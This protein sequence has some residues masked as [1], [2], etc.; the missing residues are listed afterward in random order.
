MTSGRNMR[1]QARI[2]S[3]KKVDDLTVEIKTSQCRTRSCPRRLLEISSGAA[4]IRRPGE[5]RLRQPSDRHRFV[6]A[7]RVERTGIAARGICRI[8][9]PGK[10]ETAD[11]YVAA[12]PELPGSRQLFRNRPILP[13]GCRSTTSLLSRG[14]VI[15][16]W[17]PLVPPSWRGSSWRPF[18]DSPFHDKRGPARRQPCYR[19][20][21]LERRVAART[22]PARDTSAPLT[23]H[24]ATTQTLRPIRTI[25]RGRSNCLPRPDT[26]TALT[27]RRRSF[28]EDRLATPRSIRRSRSNFLRL[29]LG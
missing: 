6:Q 10:C 7:G 2:A 4:S 25:Q 9:A 24:L 20:Q 29:A 26:Q 1:T 19:P 5:Q 3:I 28:R 21:C 27:P 12:G 11:Y 16:L 14:R 17:P 18:L 23:S 13:L 15:R 8:L 22:K